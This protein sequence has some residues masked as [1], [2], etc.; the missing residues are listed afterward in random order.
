[1]AK[2]N[3]LLQAVT[4]EFH[5]N[6]LKKLL[7]T[8]KLKSF[9]ASVAFVREDGVSLVESKLKQLAKVSSFFVGIRNGIT[10]IQAIK[11][12]L[13]L[14][15]RVYAV[16]TGS[17]STLFHPKV[18]LAK[19]KTIASAIIGS[20]NMTFGGLNRNIEAGAIL[21]LDLA[22]KDDAAFLDSTLKLF[23]DLPKRYP[24]H[25]F[26]IKGTAVAEALFNDGRLADE[27]VVIAP[28]VA[29]AV[30]SGERDKLKPMK[31]V[32]LGAPMRKVAKRSI[33]K[34]S[35]K[36]LVAIP[37]PEISAT[38]F[39]FVWES[40]GLTERD[41]NIPTGRNTNPTGSM[42][43]KKGAM[44]GIDQRHFFRDKVFS[45]LLWKKDSAKPHMERAEANF[46]IIV[47]GLNYGLFELKLSHNTDTT[48]A[49]YAQ[50]NSMTQVHWR[51]ALSCI[52]KRD[53]LGRTMLLYRKEGT[54]PEF[55]I[56]ID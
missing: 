1:M 28:S 51:R 46:Q 27:D 12:L 40:R 30:R 43:W 10:S 22:N 54:P 13:T 29:T 20:A 41:L 6:A 11:R 45:G 35:Q 5:A 3:F 48:S 8:P 25:V 16:D 31:L 26:E 56:E 15:V 53:L 23:E 19:G 50:R 49:S 44:E 33:V 42:L 9:V 38:K 36:N 52:A 7:S 17:R 55:I 4:T 37:A 21:A 24:E 14:G 32:Q 47:K 34:S 18:F 2:I 39:I